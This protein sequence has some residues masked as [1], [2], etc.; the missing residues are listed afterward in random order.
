MAIVTVVL[1]ILPLLLVIALSA[2]RLAGHGP[3]QPLWTTPLSFSAIATASALTLFA[4]TGFEN[5]SAP[6]GKV[7]NSHRVIPLALLIG[8][9][10]VALL[11]LGSSSSVMLLLS[12]EQIA[13]SPAP[14]A[15]A[16]AASWGEVAAYLTS[17]AIA[18]SAFGCIGCTM[19]AAGELCFSLAQRRDLPVA[20]AR[21]NACG[22]P[23][24]AQL[25][26]AM[27]SILLVLAN[28]SRTTAGLFTFIILLSTVAVLILYVVAALATGIRERSK[29]VRALVVGGTLF[30]AFAFYGSG[31]EASLWGLGLACFALPVRIIS[32][33]LNG[34]SPEAVAYRA[35]PPESI[36]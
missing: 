1:R 13:R 10:L 26:S 30:A 16:I 34:S 18:I 29:G 3:V 5:V 17:F 33:L 6:I 25:I 8:V 35:S 7:E 28:S 12:P 31:L 22:A 20:L 14:Y 11:Y 23:M 27:L 24:T 2:V 32:R 4:L 15:D 36:S 19:M 21:T 9:S